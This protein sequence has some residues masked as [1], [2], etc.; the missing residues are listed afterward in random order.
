MMRLRWYFAA[1]VILSLALSLPLRLILSG[2][3]EVIAARSV[4]GTIWNGRL[5]GAS[6]GGQ[7][8]GDLDARL[9]LWPL[10]I[11]RA[12]VGLDGPALHG[13]I[14][15]GFGSRGADIR[16]LALPTARVY[17]PVT[18]SGF[19]ISDAHIAFQDNGCA[20]ASGRVL[21]LLRTGFGDHRLSGSL[22]CGGAALSTDLI[23]QSA[24]Q[25]LS[26]RFPDARHFQA[27]L[28]VRASDAQQAAGLA[29]AGFRETPIG[30]VMKFSGVL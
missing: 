18:L 20:K 24:M 29:S 6:L 8:L 15:A 17:G 3:G 11:G 10:F 21:L 22:R 7:P 14:T 9:A 13:A 16:I 28:V 19:D 1:A 4:E 5:M 30:H 26:L 12:R 2:T 27:T 25:R 23:S